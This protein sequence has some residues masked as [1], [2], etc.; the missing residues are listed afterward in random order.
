M[1]VRSFNEKKTIEGPDHGVARSP[2][3][4]EPDPAPVFLLDRAAKRLFDIIAATIGL[5]IFSPTFLLV[6]IAIKIESRGPVLRRQM[7]YG[8]NN[9]NIPLLKF[10][11]TTVRLTGR[12]N[13]YVTRVGSILRR[14]GI[15]GLPQLINILHGEMTIVGPSPYVVVPNKTFAEQI[16][17]IRRR[18]RVKPGII[19]WA[20]VNG[21]W[22]E[23]NAREVTRR[24][25]EYDLYYINNW[26]FLFDIKIILMNLFSKDSYPNR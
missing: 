21:Y 6:S 5:L 4:R 15:D 1:A 25:I 18:Q 24:R 2:E 7:R 9:E 19:G 10:R 13:S 12:S 14:T 20:Q 8:Y 26:S 11:S 22:G 17:I 16:S 3:L 23:S